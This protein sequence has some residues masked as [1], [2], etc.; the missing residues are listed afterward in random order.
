LA[1]LKR[2]YGRRV[3][4]FPGANKQVDGPKKLPMVGSASRFLG[5]VSDG[6]RESLFVI[7][8]IR[9]AGRSLKKS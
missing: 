9:R 2:R 8:A 5:G 1:G 7:P 4:I 3:Q 6:N